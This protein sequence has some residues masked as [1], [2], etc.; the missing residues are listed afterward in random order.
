MHS[1]SVRIFHP[2]I[3]KRNVSV[4]NSRTIALEANTEIRLGSESGN[5]VGGVTAIVI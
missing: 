1:L 5:S 3:N 2:R 4:F